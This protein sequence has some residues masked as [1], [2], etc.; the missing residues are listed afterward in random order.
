MAAQILTPNNLTKSKHGPVPKHQLR[1]CRKPCP[2]EFA[3]KLPSCSCHEMD[4]R[5]TITSIS[6]RIEME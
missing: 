6:M 3:V 1:R 5:Y 4:L 2:N